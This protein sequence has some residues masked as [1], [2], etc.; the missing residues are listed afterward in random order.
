MENSVYSISI[1]LPPGANGTSSRAHTRPSKNDAWWFDTGL[2]FHF[3]NGR[4]NNN[5]ENNDHHSEDDTHSPH[6]V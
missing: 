5:D 3:K 4:D 1:F 6:Y 2:L